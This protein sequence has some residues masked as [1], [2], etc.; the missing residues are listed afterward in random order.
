L[1]KLIIVVIILVI[2]LLL[3]GPVIY[4][5]VTEANRLKK[6]KLIQATVSKEVQD[7]GT[8]LKEIVSMAH[9]ESP[10]LT[11][12]YTGKTRANLEPCG[13]YVGQSGGVSRR[14]TA[15]EALR[16]NGWNPIVLDAGHF[17]DG[18]EDIDK[19]RSLTNMRAMVQIEYDAIGVSSRDLV[20]GTEF[21]E[22]HTNDLKLP[23]ICENLSTHGWCESHITL[24]VAGVKVTVFSISDL[25]NPKMDL[26]DIVRKLKTSVSRTNLATSVTLLLSS[27]PIEETRRLIQEVPQFDVAICTETEADEMVGQTHILGCIPDGEFL[28]FICLKLASLDEPLE[29]FSKH[30]IRLSES[31]QNDTKTDQLL[32]NFYQQIEE[33]AKLHN[34]AST[35]LFSSLTLEREVNSGYTG[36]RTCQSCHRKEYE[37]WQTTPHA[38]AFHTLKNVQRYFDPA[39]VSCHV[40]GHGYETGYKI[41]EPIE[42]L[43]GVG[44]ETCHGPGKQHIIDPVSSNIRGKVPESICLECHNSKHSPRFEQLIEHVMPDVDHS[45]APKNIEAIISQKAS[46][47]TRPDI[48]LFVMSFCP[49]G[50]RA[51]KNLLPIIKK[52][53]DQVDFSIHFI[54]T[55]KAAAESGKSES[56]TKKETYVSVVDRFESLHGAREVAESMRQIIVSKLYPDVFFDYLLW[57]ADHPSDSWRKGAEPLGIDVNRVTSLIESKESLTWFLENIAL[58]KALDIRISPTLHIDGYNYGRRIYTT[59]DRTCRRR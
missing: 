22:K 47:T 53:E 32:G 21:L 14:R 56:D 4:N 30:Q 6:V 46:G 24:E 57:R 41:A 39:C 58:V 40:V 49:F 43:Q 23:L 5:R 7:K 2:P 55:D 26:Q 9:P 33:N 34:A 42:T 8:S 51:E 12:V 35:P 44:C 20:F 50:T 54:A 1:K 27:M 11:L 29:I 15:I 3:A 19:A 36:S 28:G 48:D 31:V 25:E 10:S 17:V 13:C 38:R 37:Q 52:Y 16:K 59:S 18:K 45:R